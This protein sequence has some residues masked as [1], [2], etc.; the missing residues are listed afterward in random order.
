MEIKLNAILK[1]EAK[2][3]TVNVERGAEVDKY[4]GVT[5][6]IIRQ[7][8]VQSELPLTGPIS[9][10]IE[11]FIVGVR[12]ESEFREVA[13]GVQRARGKYVLPDN[14]EVTGVVEFRD[15]QSLRI[16][17]YGP[18]REGVILL[19]ELIRSG[20]IRPIGDGWDKEQIDGGPDR[21]EEALG[22]LQVANA[23]NE[24]L[25]Q[26]VAELRGARDMFLN[27]RAE[28]EETREALDL[29]QATFRTCEQNFNCACEK[30]VLLRQFA[31][32]MEGDF[33][34]LIFKSQVAKEINAILDAK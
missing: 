27:I 11:P 1:E 22:L 33:L 24:H 2:P 4:I 32:S 14:D 13:L 3:R 25:T 15:S 30:N 18:N 17:C 10:E 23:E 6:V 12:L 28:L 29:S 31:R 9:E 19:Y 20:K 7:G 34:P 21:L 5:R 8:V 16:S 26:E